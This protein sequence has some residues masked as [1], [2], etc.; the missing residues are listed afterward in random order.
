MENNT[1]KRKQSLR[2]F[3]INT[4]DTLLKLLDVRNR[5]VLQMADSIV[6]SESLVRIARIEYYNVN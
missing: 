5:N 2:M 6:I 3:E 4:F 1:S